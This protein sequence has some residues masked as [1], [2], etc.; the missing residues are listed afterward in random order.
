MCGHTNPMNLR[1]VTYTRYGALVGCL[2]C[3][4][5]WLVDLNNQAQAPATS[6]GDTQ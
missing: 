4:T 6:H 5:S 2:S 1:L 3:G